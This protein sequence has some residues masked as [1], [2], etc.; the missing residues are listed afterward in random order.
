MINSPQTCLARPAD[1]TNIHEWRYFREE[2]SFVSRDSDK[3]RR[4]IY[5]YCVYCRQRDVEHEEFWR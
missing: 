3:R 1:G 4:S 5:Y 2:E